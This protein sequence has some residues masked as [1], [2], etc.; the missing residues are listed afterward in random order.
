MSEEN[1]EVVRAALEVLALGQV[2]KCR[3]LRSAS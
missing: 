2:P 1:V 3:L